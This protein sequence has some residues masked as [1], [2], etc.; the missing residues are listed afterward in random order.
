[1]ERLAAGEPLDPAYV[2]EEG[3]AIFRSA[4]RAAYQVRPG[5]ETAQG[6]AAAK[7]ESALYH[8]ALRL[9]LRRFREPVRLGDLAAD[10]QI[11]APHLSRLFR[12][13][14][15]TSVHKTLVELRLRDSL[16]ALR[17]PGA[18]LSRL[19]L[20]LGFTSHSH[21]SATFRRY[22]EVTPSQVRGRI[23]RRQQRD[24]MESWLATARRVTGFSRDF[25]R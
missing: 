18:D 12:T 9:V 16:E 19:A 1:M 20:D 21:F 8:R 23:S 6:R 13:H 11:S 22:F 15:G 7:A 3:L 5:A 2:E 25:L 14:Q 17:D 4:L 24:W 10:L